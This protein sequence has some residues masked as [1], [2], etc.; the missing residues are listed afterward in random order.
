MIHQYLFLGLVS[1]L[2]IS[3]FFPMVETAIDHQLTMQL[4]QVEKLHEQRP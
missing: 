1:I 3:L 4:N 2:L